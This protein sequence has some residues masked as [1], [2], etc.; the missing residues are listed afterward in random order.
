MSSRVQHAKSQEEFLK[1]L[2]HQ[3]DLQAVLNQKR[4]LPK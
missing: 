3:A 1:E 4:W 2:Q